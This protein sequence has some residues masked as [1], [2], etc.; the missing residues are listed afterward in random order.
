M[1]VWQEYHLA[2]SWTTLEQAMLSFHGLTTPFIN[3]P[4]QRMGIGTQDPTM[5]LFSLKKLGHHP[6]LNDLGPYG[7]R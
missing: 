1:V 6:F 4:R 5:S 2:K 3:S 7:L